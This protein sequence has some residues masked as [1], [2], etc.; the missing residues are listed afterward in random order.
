MF[1]KKGLTL[2]LLVCSFSTIAQ[3]KLSKKARKAQKKSEKFEL[4]KKSFAEAQFTFEVKSTSAKGNYKTSSSNAT[5]RGIVTVY[6]DKANVHLASINTAGYTNDNPIYLE[7]EMVIS[8]YMVSY[9]DQGTKINAT[10]ESR[11]KGNTYEFIFSATLGGDYT[12][13]LNGS[14]RDTTIYRGKLKA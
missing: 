12:L 9:L 11:Y 7:S 4:I 5:G 1:I 6:G 13:K 10:F 2:V 8:N 14:D 3:A